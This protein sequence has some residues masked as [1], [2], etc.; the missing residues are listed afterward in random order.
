MSPQGTSFTSQ[1]PVCTYTRTQVLSV[2]R[3]N[4]F[5]VLYCTEGINKVFLNLSLVQV[6]VSWC[7][8]RADL[9]QL[10]NYSLSQVNPP[11]KLFSVGVKSHL[12]FVSLSLF[13]VFFLRLQIGSW[14]PLIYFVLPS[15]L[16][17][18]RSI[19]TPLLWSHGGLNPYIE[20]GEAVG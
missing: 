3:L 13:T 15:Y 19:G 14:P 1:S 20:H 6:M 12:G 18:V 9:L 17:S 11:S 10:H 2:P 7:F 8:Q 4:H 5:S 16:M